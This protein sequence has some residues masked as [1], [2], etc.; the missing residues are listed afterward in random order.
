MTNETIIKELADIHNMII[1]ISVHGDDAII[2][3]NAILKARDLVNALR[4]ETVEEFSE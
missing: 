2:M 1:S 3:A 4:D